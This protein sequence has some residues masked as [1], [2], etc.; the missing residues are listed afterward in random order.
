MAHKETNRNNVISKILLLKKYISKVI[1][2]FEFANLALLCL[3]FC[4][5]LL[6]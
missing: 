6:M 4:I 2:F 3:I 5:I 1:E